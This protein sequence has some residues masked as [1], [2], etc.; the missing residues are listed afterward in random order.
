MKP[1]STKHFIS[2][3]LLT[4]LLSISPIK[5]KLPEK[6]DFINLMTS[7]GQKVA[8]DLTVHKTPL[9]NKYSFTEKDGDKL[10]IL[11][12]GELITAF[13][14]TPAT[15]IFGTV[16]AGLIQGLGDA[17]ILTTYNKHSVYMKP[18]KS[19]YVVFFNEDTLQVMPYQH[20]GKFFEMVKSLGG[21]K[22]PYLFKAE[23]SWSK[24]V[25]GEGV[26]GPGMRVIVPEEGPPSY[27]EALTMPSAQ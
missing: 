15:E 24:S 7:D 4:G 16:T 3:F 22:N 8:E 11:H 13:K 2:L 6:G 19:Y 10:D 25:I 17:F 18:D 5:A 20:E 9:I 27:E 21:Q 1:F 23:K 12:E 26:A 14:I